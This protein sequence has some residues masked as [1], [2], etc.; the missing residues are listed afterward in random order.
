MTC[1]RSLLVSLLF[2]VL[3]APAPAGI[4]FGK[5]STKPSPNERV[6]ELLRTVR[7]DGDEHKRSAA[8][9]ELRQFDPK[10]FPEIV[11]VLIDVLLRDPKP[12]VRAEAA[13]SLG[14][15]QPV[16]E[17]AGWALEQAL[18]K[19]NSMRVRLQ[20]RSA[21]ILYHWRGYH[22]GKDAP[23]AQSKEPP[24]AG[25]PL[26]EPPVIQTAP[27]ESTS[28]RPKPVPAAVPPQAAP[29]QPAPAPAPPP[30]ANTGTGPRPLPPGPPPSSAE[31]PRLQP[32]PAGPVEPGP[33]LEPPPQG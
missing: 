4:I 8:A 23:P 19:D 5:K 1:I 32:L 2:A 18:S 20:A 12:T 28:L 29:A 26:A 7:T 27:V 14:K 33:A 22:G 10:Q 31:P 17:Q 11:P 25:P 3:V 16:S 6:P 9:E 21:L 13:Q 24:L 30:T 15:I